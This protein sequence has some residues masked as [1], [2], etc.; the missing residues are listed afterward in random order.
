MII[1]RHVIHD[2]SIFP[3][4]VCQYSQ[5]SIELNPV[6]SVSSSIIRL[7]L[8]VVHIHATSDGPISEATGTSL[9]SLSDS[10]NYPVSSFIATRSSFVP[11]LLVLSNAQ[12][13]VTLPLSVASD[14]SSSISHIYLGV[15]ASLPLEL[16]NS[17]PTQ[18]RLKD[19][20]IQKKQCREFTS[21]GN[22]LTSV[23]EPNTPSH[24]KDAAHNL[25]WQAVMTE[26]I[27]ALQLQGTWSLALAP[28][29]KNIVG[30]R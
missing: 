13:E 24:F 20:I 12:L 1:S 18:T 27:I 10:I 8:V 3:L 17:H 4:K 21:F 11:M 7:T 28:H 25:L 30:G 5:E 26:E 2:E 23:L 6:Y 14:R 15:N 29:D 19:G 22:V 16:M 9:S